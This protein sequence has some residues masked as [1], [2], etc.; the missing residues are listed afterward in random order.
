MNN[1]LMEILRELICR[2]N[3]M[4]YGTPMDDAEEC[5]LTQAHDQMT[6][7]IPR[8]VEE[9]KYEFEYCHCDNPKPK[10]H[11]GWMCDNCTRPRLT[12]FQK[13]GE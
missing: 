3:G 8:T 9:I 2:E 13:E 5:N 4:P 10:G 6:Q 7:Y 12:D 11:N 1:K